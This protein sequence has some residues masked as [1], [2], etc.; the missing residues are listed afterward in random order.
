VAA[1][2]LEALFRN[3]YRGASLDVP[4]IE[5][6]EVGYLAPDGVMVRH[7]SFKSAEELKSFCVERP[8]LG[9]YY[10]AALYERPDERDMD[11]K[12][13]LGADLV[14]DIDATISTRPAA[15]GWSSSTTDAS[16]TRGRRR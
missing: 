16:R 4:E 15:E 1:R 8:P 5:R 6:R 13:W 11:A 14:F 9:L 3:Y 7:R 2:F 10:S 12:G